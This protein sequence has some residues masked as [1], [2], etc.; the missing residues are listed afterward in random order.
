MDVA[1]EPRPEHQP[2]EPDEPAPD[3]PAQVQP[4]PDRPE[5][6]E[7]DISRVERD[8]GPMRVLRKVTSPR[9]EGF[10]VVIQR[11]ALEAIHAHGREDTTVEICG[12]LVGNLHHDRQGPYLLIDAH[13]PGEKATSRGTQ[14]TFTAE[15]WEGIQKEME[16]HPDQK[17]VGWYHTHP[18][19]GV[20]LSGMDL[21][22][23]DNFF[24][25]PWQ[26]AWVYDP[27]AETDGAFV[28][29]AG[30][31][32]KADFLI[33]ENAGERGHDFRK[34]LNPDGSLTSAEL[35]R[36]RGASLRRVVRAVIVFMIFF[37]VAW[38][39]LRWLTDHGY[40]VRWPIER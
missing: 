8:N 24:N 9:G 32:E 11:S 34:T 40:K 21:F 7:L 33:E 31:S 23:Q 27:I 3:Q 5:R 35:R 25:L 30:K 2:P 39:G 13:V 4:A 16:K 18:G 36:L 26:V 14:V 28:W 12:V 37:L 22:I 10:E 6:P 38:F 15:T 20:F 29:R 19:F 1:E 17:I